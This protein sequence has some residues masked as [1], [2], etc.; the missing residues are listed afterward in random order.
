VCSQRAPAPEYDAAPEPHYTQGSADAII[1]P[2]ASGTAEDGYKKRGS[3]AV[4]KVD[5]NGYYYLNC[6][7]EVGHEIRAIL[8]GADGYH[9]RWEGYGQIYSG[10]VKAGGYGTKDYLQVQDLTT[11]ETEYFRFQFL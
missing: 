2:S 10:P 7:G 1:G 5:A 8:Q 4:S 11:G 6:A 3:I 9:R